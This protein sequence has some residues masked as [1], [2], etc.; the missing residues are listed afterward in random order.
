MPVTE[1]FS[2]QVYKQTKLIERLAKQLKA[3]AKN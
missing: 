3:L 1:V 2:V